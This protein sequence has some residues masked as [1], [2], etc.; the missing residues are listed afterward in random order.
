MTILNLYPELERLGAVCLKDQNGLTVFHCA[1]CSRNHDLIKC[2]LSSSPE[3]QQLQYVNMIDMN[4]MTALHHAV[5]S[6]N[7]QSIDVILDLYPEADRFIQNLSAYRLLVCIVQRVAT[8]GESM[9]TIITWLPESQRLHVVS[10]QDRHGR[11]S[12]SSRWLS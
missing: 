7:T 2:L 3:L 5:C 6:G 11:T 9:E 1:A 12:N 4:G 10:V 8:G